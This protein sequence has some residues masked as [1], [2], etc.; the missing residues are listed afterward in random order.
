MLELA[1]GEVHFAGIAYGD[2]AY[3]SLYPRLVFKSFVPGQTGILLQ[4]IGVDERKTA[5]QRHMALMQRPVPASVLEGET[6]ETDITGAV[7]DDESFDA[8]ALLGGSQQETAVAA[9]AADDGL[10]P[11]MFEFQPALGFKEG[12]D[13]LVALPLHV[14]YAEDG[15]G[16]A[17]VDYHLQVLRAEHIL[18][19][20]GDGDGTIVGIESHYARHAIVRP[21][22]RVFLAWVAAECGTSLAYNGQWRLFRATV[23]GPQEERLRHIVSSGGDAD[24]DTSLTAAVACTSPLSSLS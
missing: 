16:P 5:L 15:D 13:S 23:L 10:R 6:L 9:F 3:R 21:Y 17:L 19:W 22:L 7:D 11:G 18:G 24:G 1:I 12:D 8:I 2:S 14:L 20:S 4:F